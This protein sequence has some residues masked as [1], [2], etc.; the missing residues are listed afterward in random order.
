[1]TFYIYLYAQLS[2]IL[3]GLPKHELR[4]LQPRYEAQPI[5]HTPSP[6]HAPVVFT[7]M[8]QRVHDREISRQH[9]QSTHDRVIRPPHVSVKPTT[10]DS[11]LGALHLS[12]GLHQ[13]TAS[14]PFDR[15]VRP[16]NPRFCVESGSPPK[17]IL[18]G[19]EPLPHLAVP[20]HTSP[21]ESLTTPLIIN[22]DEWSDAGSNDPSP[23]RTFSPR[24]RETN[25]ESSTS[26]DLPGSGSPLLDRI[27]R[28]RRQRELDALSCIS[29]SPR[30]SIGSLPKYDSTALIGIGQGHWCSHSPLPDVEVTLVEDEGVDELSWQATIDSANAVLSGDDDDDD[31]DMSESSSNSSNSHK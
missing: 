11:S 13:A 2:L 21:R 6:R 7:D 3:E 12:T 30:S 17:D 26:W 28:A 20:S 22:K 8:L 15:A 9:A 18:W 5:I 29:G 25:L 31:V 24:Y 14:L 10:Y 27:A 1:M 19:I 16:K 4:F 23:G